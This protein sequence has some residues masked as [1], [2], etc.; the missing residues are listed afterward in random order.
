M[1]WFVN[2]YWHPFPSGERTFVG[3][4]WHGSRA[5]CDA[6]AE[7]ELRDEPKTRRVGVWHIRPKLK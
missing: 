6:A 5:V 2:V 7:E 4:A 1:T 3:R